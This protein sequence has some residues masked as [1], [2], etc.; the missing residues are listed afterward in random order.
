MK[1]SYL[2]LLVFLFLFSCRSPKKNEVTQSRTTGETS[3]LVDESF[4]QVLDAQ[5][6]VFSVEYPNAT[7]KSILENEN[8]IMPLFL[9]RK[10]KAA[11]LSRMLTD[12]EQKNYTS[13][14]I[15][16]YTD[17]FAI[18]GIA[19]ITN[20]ENADSTINS[21]DIISILKGENP[22]GINLVFDNPHSSTLRYFKDLAKIK[23][24]PNKHIFTLQNSNEV[25]K[26]I[27]SHQNYVGVIGVNWLYNNEKSIQAQLLK[28]KTMAVKNSDD[29]EY[30][31]PTQEN[32]ISGRY[33]FLRN[34]YILNAE[35]NGNLGTG[36]A[37]WLCSPRGQLIVLKSGLAPHKLNPR[38]LN[39]KTNK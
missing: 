37:N 17:R 21:Q 22:K 39:I 6:Q 25:I 5:I 27:A 1:F 38:E 35:G 36:F 16:V 30:Y 4:A 33:P 18:D 3:I 23:D 13:K 9:N 32:L 15:I 14:G 8:K 12:K 10:I 7:V 34:I 29:K 2:S 11:V 20:K 24:L 28:I 19:L 31:K 26:Y